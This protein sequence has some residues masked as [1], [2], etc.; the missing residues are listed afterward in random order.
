M[1]FLER[2]IRNW[3]LGWNSNKESSLDTL[4][5]SGPVAFNS[6]ALPRPA[7]IR[8]IMDTGPN[9]ALDTRDPL[10][11]AQALRGGPIVK[12]TPK[13]TRA[14]LHCAH[15]LSL[16]IKVGIRLVARTQMFIWSIQHSITTLE[17]AFL[18]SKWLQAL[19]MPDPDPPV[20]EDEKRMLSLLRTMLAE[21]EFALPTEMS[22]DSP[23]MNK[24]LNAGILRV[25]A[26]IFKG[27]Q[28]WAVVD[29]VGSAL[30]SYADLL[31][32]A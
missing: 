25:W 23:R 26:T 32:R 21:T 16:P 19:D 12:R 11:I 6:T 20:S 27:G 30:D 4:A 22:T 13:L 9:R 14:I 10:Q 18:L 5:P 3:Q 7:Y 29:V 28:T 17:C 15:T 8:T 24:H 2:A 1:T 31:E